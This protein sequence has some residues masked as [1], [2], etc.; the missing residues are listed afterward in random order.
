MPHND[1]GKR[2]EGNNCGAI[3]TL[4]QVVPSVSLKHSSD[5]GCASVLGVVELIGV[6][7]KYCYGAHVV[8]QP[9]TILNSL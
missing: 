9:D 7:V 8:S 3:A 6:L 5:R 2:G 1:E 4:H